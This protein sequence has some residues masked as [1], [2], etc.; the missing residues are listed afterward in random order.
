MRIITNSSFNSTGKAALNGRTSVNR[1]GSSLGSGNQDKIEFSQ[2]ARQYKQQVTSQSGVDSSGK[3]QQPN[4]GVTTLSED[5]ALL[6]NLFQSYNSKCSTGSAKNYLVVFDG[7]EEQ[8]RAQQHFKSEIEKAFG[9]DF[10]QSPRYQA[11][12]SEMIGI[13][14]A[15]SPSEKIKAIAA[16][17]QTDGMSY[18]DGLNMVMDLASTGA[19]DES[20]AFQ[21]IDAAFRAQFTKDCAAYET[22]TGI[23]P[24]IQKAWTSFFSSKFSWNAMLD[25]LKELVSNPRQHPSTVIQLNDFLDRFDQS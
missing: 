18:G 8:Y 7:D 6:D 22:R 19:M 9:P 3:A 11:A 20:E 24:D 21:A 14:P 1:Q 12:Y 2:L 5:A 17:Y 15:L 16:K 23:E 10:M 25:N 13:D 4:T